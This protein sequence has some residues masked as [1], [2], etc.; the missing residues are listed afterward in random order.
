MMFLNFRKKD[1]NIIITFGGN[2]CGQRQRWVAL[3]YSYSLSS[4]LTSRALANL[5][6]RHPRNPEPLRILHVRSYDG[7]HPGLFGPT[8]TSPN[9]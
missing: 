6:P 5:P 2:L 7:I 8:G 1:K 3:C 4:L 9:L